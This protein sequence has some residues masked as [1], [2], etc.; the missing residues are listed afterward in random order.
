MPSEGGLFAERP[1]RVELLTNRTTAA[2]RRRLVGGL[3]RG[4]VDILVG[5]HALLY[6]DAPFSRLGVVVIDEQHRF[7]VEQRALLTGRDRIE[8]PKPSRRRSP[9][10]S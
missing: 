6:G 4:E 7:G 8:M 10:C 2:E 3:E 1:V 5:T 9:T